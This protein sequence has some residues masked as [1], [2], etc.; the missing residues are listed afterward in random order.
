MPAVTTLI[1]TGFNILKRAPATQA[2]N[3]IIGLSII[4]AITLPNYASGWSGVAGELLSNS[5]LVGA[6]SAIVLQIILVNLPQ[7]IKGIEG[8]NE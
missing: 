7:M 4:L 1:M 6:L 2:D 8:T 3:M 5:I